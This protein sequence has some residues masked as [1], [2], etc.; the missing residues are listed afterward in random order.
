M[1]RGRTPAHS[2]ERSWGRSADER[3]VIDRFNPTPG[4]QIEHDN[5][6]RLHSSRHYLWS[7][8]YYRGNPEP[9]L[10]ERCPK[11]Q[12]AG[13]LRKQENPKRRQQT[14]SWPEEKNVTY[15]PTASISL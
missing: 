13:A 1:A 8:D 4:E 12:T 7:A 3:G 6:H 9:L 2:Q 10:A 14:R 15:R 5:Q 11:A